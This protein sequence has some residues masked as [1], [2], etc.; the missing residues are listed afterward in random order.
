MAW[1]MTALYI[2]ITLGSMLGGFVI[3]KW[4]YSFL[5]YACSIAAI[6]S[7]ILSTQNVKET[8]TKSAVTN[9]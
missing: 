4:G 6:L 5:P 8:K 2:G 1:N 9:T 7:F 3:S